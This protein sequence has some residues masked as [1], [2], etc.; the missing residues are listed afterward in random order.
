MGLREGSLSDAVR[1][2]ALAEGMDPDT[3]PFLLYRALVLRIAEHRELERDRATTLFNL[4]CF[5]LVHGKDMNYWDVAGHLYPASFVRKQREE[6]V[7]NRQRSE[8]IRTMEAIRQFQMV[9]E[10]E[11]RMRRGGNA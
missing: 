11:E 8:Q 1:V 4:A 7:L 6:I 2:I 3:S 10:E 5:H 9:K